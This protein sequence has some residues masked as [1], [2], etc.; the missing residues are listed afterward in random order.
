[1]MK[2]NRRIEEKRNGDRVGDG[3][4]TWKYSSWGNGG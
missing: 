4:E 2:K 3:R 1:M